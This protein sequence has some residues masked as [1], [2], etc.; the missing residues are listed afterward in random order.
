MELHILTMSRGDAPRLRDWILYHHEIGFNY[1]H[2]ILDA[3][4]DESEN[5]LKEISAVV[6]LNLDTVSYT[7]LTLPTKA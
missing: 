3:P 4:N 1:F 6:P 7:H 2:I 5:V